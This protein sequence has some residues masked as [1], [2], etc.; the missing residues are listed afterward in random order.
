MWMIRAGSG[1]KHIEEFVEH[2]IVALGDT[3]L[4]AL[5]PSITKEGLL[6]LYA[7]RYPE[8]PEASRATW[9]SQLLRFVTE[10]KVGDEV[11]TYDRERR[12][13]LLGKITSE[14]EWAPK[15]IDTMPH[16]RRVDWTQEV[17]R[18][19]L[20]TGS[21]NSLGAIQTLFK[22][23]SD[24]AKDLRGHAAPIGS[25]SMP[26]KVTHKK[27]GSPGDEATLANLVEET[28]EKADEFIE[29]AMNALDWKQ[30]Q[31][32]VAGILRAM[33]YRTSV[34]EAGP[35][36][37]VDIFASPDG[38]GL[39]EPRIFV[40]VKHRNAAMGSKE[41]RAFLGGRKRGDRCLYVS[42]GGFSKDAHYEA[43]RADVATTLITLPVLRK[44]L[45]D[46][47]DN[48]DAETRAIV[49]LR[50]LYWPIATE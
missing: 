43:D 30:M 29:D 1:S 26:A 35:D 33:G 20:S 28:I 50:R 11:T 21:R 32:L 16:V 7:E 17:L 12:K 40:E 49:P 45:I 6:K 27:S 4:G 34:S 48:L 31:H 39:Q 13:Y 2:K 23:S 42:T 15:L 8:L 10:V 47:Y 46:H 41:I 38:L 24:V 3:K 22:L 37:G 18:D 5:A 44:L 36:R 14:Y 9:A 19:Q 25:I